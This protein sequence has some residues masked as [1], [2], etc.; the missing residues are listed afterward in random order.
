MNRTIPLIII[1]ILVSLIT[2]SLY[3]QYH[4]TKATPDTVVVTTP[5]P[6]PSPPPTPQG[7]GSYDLQAFEQELTDIIHSSKQSVVSIVATKD[8]LLYYGDPGQRGVRGQPSRQRAEIGGGSGIFAQQDG[9]IIT[10]KHVVEDPTADFLVVFAD[11]STANVTDIRL[12]P[13]IDIAV[14]KVEPSSIPTD[15]QPAR[16]ADFDRDI[17]VGQITIAIGNALNEYQN[18]VT[19]GIVSGRNRKLRGLDNNVYAGLYQTDTAISQGNSG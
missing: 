7:Q 18:S 3:S 2:S 5:P 6:S 17:R 14:V 11:N 19:L 1:T 15:A 13:L 9:Y 16:F 12:D 4:M 8:F 10:N